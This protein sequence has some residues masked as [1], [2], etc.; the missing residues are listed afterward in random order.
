MSNAIVKKSTR[1]GRG[2]N[3]LE[4]L[5]QNTQDQ[6]NRLVQQ[7]SRIV[8]VKIHYT[9]PKNYRLEKRKSIW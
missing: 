7:V 2:T 8:I 6:L 4:K 1:D 3:E 5:K 9:S